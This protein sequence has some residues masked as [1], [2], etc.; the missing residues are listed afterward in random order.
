MTSIVKPSQ[1]YTSK[2]KHINNEDP[3]QM[4]HSVVSDLGVH[5]LQYYQEEKD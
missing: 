1:I 5:C 2:I 4:L 3:D